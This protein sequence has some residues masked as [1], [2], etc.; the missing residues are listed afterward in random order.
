MTAFYPRRPRNE[1]Q[2]RERIDE[3]Q[4]QIADGTLLVRQMSIEEHEAAAG[5][6]R[7]SRA[8]INA[9]RKLH[10]QLTSGQR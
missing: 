6:A 10:G 1:A 9:R 8:R 7:T 3:I 2:R 5:A 4:A